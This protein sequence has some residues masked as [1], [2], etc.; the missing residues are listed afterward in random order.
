MPHLLRFE[1][2]GRDKVWWFRAKD[3]RAGDMEKI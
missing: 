1:G 3:R 2:L